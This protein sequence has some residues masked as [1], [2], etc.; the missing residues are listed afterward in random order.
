MRCLA[1]V[2][3]LLAAPMPAFASDGVLEINQTC[4]INGGCFSGDAAGFPVTI[5]T[6]GNY[7]L[8]SSLSVGAFVGGI[9]VASSDVSID[10]NGFTV[11]GVAPGGG[12]VA[13]VG[14][15]GDRIHLANG[16]ILSFQFAVLLTGSQSLV[17]KVRLGGPQSTLSVGAGS[18]V[19]NSSFGGGHG[20]LIQLGE[21]SLFE[22]NTVRGPQQ[23]GWVLTAGST[24]IIRN[25]ALYVVEA[26]INA[27]SSSAIGNVI[28]GGFNGGP[29][30]YV[31][32]GGVISENRL[33]STA[34]LPAIQATNAVVS[35]NQVVGSSNGIRCSDCTVVGNVV[36]GSSGVAL[37]ATG[38][39]GTTGYQGNQFSGN[40]GG[41]GNP[42][43]LGGVETGPNVCGGDLTCP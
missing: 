33:L 32:N 35:N 9:S 24:S 1:I 19:I 27:P 6:P 14:G 29:L 10:L 34:T 22:G 3:M 23:D 12:P 20:Q 38:S 28:N 5:T 4:A 31:P 25:N 30:I 36:S 40:N 42:Q 15:S 11:Q 41:N 2:L 43:V 16:S 13:G 39:T 21:G 26:G 18:R 17:E 8:T 7:R 37:D